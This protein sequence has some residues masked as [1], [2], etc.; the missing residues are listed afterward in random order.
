MA[1]TALD[2]IGALVALAY[3]LDAAAHELIARS[4]IP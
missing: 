2:V 1:I 4:W 3:A